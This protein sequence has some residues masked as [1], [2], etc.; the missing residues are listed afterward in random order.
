MLPVKDQPS[1]RERHWNRLK[2]LYI[3]VPRSSIVDVQE[4][5]AANVKTRI[6]KA[7]EAF[8]I[9]RNV[10]KSVHSFSVGSTAVGCNV[11]CK[12]LLSAALFI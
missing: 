7:S 5:T 11:P 9:L 6:S 10:W 8:H 12:V 3:Y 2:H 4:R 1:L